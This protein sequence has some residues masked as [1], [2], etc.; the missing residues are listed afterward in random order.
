MEY[1]IERKGMVHE[2][3]QSIQ[4]LNGLDE[5][6]VRVRYG[7]YHEIIYADD[8][9]KLTLP[10]GYYASVY[11]ERGK[12]IPCITNKGNTGSTA[13]WTFAVCTR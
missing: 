3:V 8:F 2:V 10:E 13:Y 12:E 1:S 9:S 7:S 4:N 11:Y 6:A 5:S